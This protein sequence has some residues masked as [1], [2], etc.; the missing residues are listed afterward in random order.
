MELNLL[1]VEKKTLKTVGS[2]DMS[3]SVVDNKDKNNIEAQEGW[4]SCVLCE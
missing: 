4:E 3:M 2:V 1:M